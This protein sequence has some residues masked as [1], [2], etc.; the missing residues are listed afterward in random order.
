MHNHLILGIIFLDW[1]PKHSYKEHSSK[2]NWFKDCC[3]KEYRSMN[4]GLGTLV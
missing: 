4:I 3:P 2:E 1:D